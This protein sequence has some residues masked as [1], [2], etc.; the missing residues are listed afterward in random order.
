MTLSITK[1][2]LARNTIRDEG[3]RAF[4]GNTSVTTLDLRG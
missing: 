1:L 3:A 2:K 4:A